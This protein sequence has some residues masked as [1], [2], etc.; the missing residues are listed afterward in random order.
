MFDIDLNIE[1]YSI[2]YSF[3]IIYD[4]LF[5]MVSK[6]ACHLC[7]IIEYLTKILSINYLLKDLN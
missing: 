1:T 7:Y 2:C 6:F 5:Q 4:F 3:L